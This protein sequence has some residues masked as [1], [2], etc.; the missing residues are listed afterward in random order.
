MFAVVYSFK[1]KPGMETQFVE[2]WS[3]VTRDLYEHANSLGS[4]LHRVQATD[5]GTRTDAGAVEFIAYAQWPTRELWET[6][7]VSADPEVQQAR[8]RMREACTG[9][10]TLYELEVA[11]D[12]LRPEPRAS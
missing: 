6:T 10:E 5:A 4:R 7:N 9:I 11:A 8:A 1:V 2:S 3:R 12:L